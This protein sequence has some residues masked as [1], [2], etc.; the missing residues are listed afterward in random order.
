VNFVLTSFLFLAMT[1]LTAEG[2]PPAV[3]TLTMSAGAFLIPLLTAYVCGRLGDE[4]YLTYAFY[5]LI[6]FLILAVPGVLYAGTFGLLMVLFGIL[7]AF[8]GA[9]LAARRA[10]RRRHVPKDEPD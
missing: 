9:T 8:N 10:T 7:G 6:G 4:R 3:Y 5:P 2:V 1:A